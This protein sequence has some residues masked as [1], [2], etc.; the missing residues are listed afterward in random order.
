[1]KYKAPEEGSY[2]SGLTAKLLYDTVG[3][4]I[5]PLPAREDIE[6]MIEE[7]A[8]L[9]EEKLWDKP[10]IK[11]EL[12][13]FVLSYLFDDSQPPLPTK[14]EGIFKGDRTDFFDG[15]VDYFG[16][17]VDD[18]GSRDKAYESVFILSSQLEKRG[19]R[20]HDETH[21]INGLKE[22]ELIKQNAID[23][24]GQLY[25]IYEIA[26]LSMKRVLNSY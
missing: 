22:D 13:E 15:L 26:Q 12:E 24:F 5:N 6:V 25:A 16:C 18:H 17:L 4:L 10:G 23:A 19:E 8:L 7:G 3:S 9:N 11:N 21:N 1:M 20:L 2:E 14:F